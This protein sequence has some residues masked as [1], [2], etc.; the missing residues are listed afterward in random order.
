MSSSSPR[1]SAADQA[2]VAALTQRVIAAWAYHDA[3]AF[4]DVFTEDGTMILPGIYRKGREEIRSFLVDAYANE[5]RGTQ[6]TGRPVDLRFLTEDTA[7]LL[8]RGGVLAEGESEVSDDQAIRA[9][10]LVVRQDG[11]WRL[12]AY[13]NTPA[14]H[15]LPTPGAT[16]R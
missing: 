7:L 5:Y 6:V 12:A 9:S 10:W 2:A 4:A 8:T 16:G 13:Q 14:V 1:A 15:R 11:E 3:D